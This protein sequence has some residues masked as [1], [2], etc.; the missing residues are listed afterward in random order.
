MNTIC[1]YS[2]ILN[3]KISHKVGGID[4]IQQQQN[5]RSQNFKI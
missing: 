2:F 4:E 5:Y 3:G 1:F